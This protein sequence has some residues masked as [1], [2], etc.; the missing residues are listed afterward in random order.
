VQTARQAQ[1]LGGDP[2]VFDLSKVRRCSGLWS[3][4]V[5]WERKYEADGDIVKTNSHATLH[6][7]RLTTSTWEIKPNVLTEVACENCEYRMYEATWRGS[8]SME[9]S[10][11][12]EYGNCR[13][14]TSEQGQIA[15]TAPSAIFIGVAGDRRSFSLF[16]PSPGATGSPPGPPWG[17][18]SGDIEGT[19]VSSCPADERTVSTPVIVAE[20]WAWPSGVGT[21]PLERTDPTIPW[22][23]AGQHVTRFEATD[24]GIPNV[25]TDTWTWKLTLEPDA[26]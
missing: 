23:S 13:D 15:G 24:E 4:T 25:I 20:N 2:E 21:L 1:L 16:R 18:V 17:Q 3:G 7:H 14:T 11:V 6:H 22:T 5:T 8:E 26:R 12:F 9:F 19:R 10:Y